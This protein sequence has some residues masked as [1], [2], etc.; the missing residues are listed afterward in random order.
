MKPNRRTEQRSP[1]TAHNTYSLPEEYPLEFAL[2]EIA[3]CHFL[4]LATRF[5]FGGFTFFVVVLFILKLHHDDDDDNTMHWKHNA[6]SH[7][8]SMNLSRAKC[9]ACISVLLDQLLVRMCSLAIFVAVCWCWKCSCSWSI[10]I[11]FDMIVAVV[12]CVHNIMYTHS[13]VRLHKTIHTLHR[14]ETANCWNDAS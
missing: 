2:S 6:A 10:C 13:S 9:I 7:F 11:G 4:M 14:N 3:I 12:I 5:S 8:A 1:N